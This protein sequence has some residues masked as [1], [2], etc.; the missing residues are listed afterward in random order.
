MKS[1]SAV[2][3]QILM[4]L[5]SSFAYYFFVA[6]ADGTKL[7]QVGI[8]VLG[9]FLGVLFLFLDQSFFAPKYFQQGVAKKVVMTRSFLFVLA[10]IPLGIFLI[11]SSGSNLGMGMYFALFSG[12]IIEMIL[13]RNDSVRFNN[14]FLSQLKTPFAASQVKMYLSGLVLFWIYLILQLF[15]F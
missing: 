2:A 6:G 14:L 9:L 1:V 15:I 10:L 8:F 4:A 3:L 11:T 7:L 13:Q 5:L 12:I